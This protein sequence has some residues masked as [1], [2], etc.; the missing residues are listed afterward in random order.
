MDRAETPKPKPKQKM[1]PPDP[2]PIEA[3]ATI[4]LPGL[5]AGQSATVHPDDPYIAGLIRRGYLVTV[6]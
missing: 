3:R 6:S 1:K 5:P 4:N 2:Q